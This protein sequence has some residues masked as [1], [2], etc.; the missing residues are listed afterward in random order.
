MKKIELELSLNTGLPEYELKNLLE[1]VAGENAQIELVSESLSDNKDDDIIDEAK[2]LGQI[3]VEQGS[4]SPTELEKGLRQHKKLGERLIENGVVQPDKI[5]AA[6]AEQKQ[7]KATIEKRARIERSS[8]IR[9]SSEKL[10]KLFDLIGELVTAQE[11]LSQVSSLVRKA[12]GQN[13]A[14]VLQEFDLE[15]ISEEISLLTNNLRDNALSVRML[16]IESTFTK[17]KRLVHDLSVDL[18]KEMDLTMSGTE[19]ELDKT[20]ID[21]LDEPLMHMIRN[22][23]DHAIE[24]PDVRVAAGKP[25]RGKIH[26]SAEHVAGNVVIHVSDDGK[27]LNK[28]LILKRAIEREIVPVG[29]HLSDR[30]I[31][32][33][34]FMPGFSTAKEVTSVS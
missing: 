15:G 6:L 22:C 28:E 5:T 13:L 31:Y 34:I 16:P 10:D 7:Q 19:T 11:R 25:R 9:V 30:E 23:A 8:N 27:G 3:L 29:A 18:E 1:L 2:P 33:L 12:E 14:K 4:L 21:K 32:G 24:L 17:F 26:L 20:V